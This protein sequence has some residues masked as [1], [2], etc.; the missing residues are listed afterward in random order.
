MNRIYGWIAGRLWRRIFFNHLLIVLVTALILQMIF[1]GFAVSSIRGTS[2]L[3]GDAGWLARSYANSISWIMETGEKQQIHPFLK[4]VRQRSVE[5]PDVEFEVKIKHFYIS[6]PLD[7]I[8]RLIAVR[9]LDLDGTIIAENGIMGTFLSQEIEWDG[10]MDMVLKGEENPYEL[11][12]M[13]HMDGES[14]LLGAA[15]IKQDGGSINGVILVEMHPAIDLGFDTR[16]YVPVFVFVAGFLATSSIGVPA[17]LL[18]MFMAALSGAIVTRSFG[19]RLME[20]GNTAR[21]IS[22]GQLSLRVKDTS[23]DEIGEVGSAFNR[24]ADQLGG[25]LETLDTEKAHVETLLRTRRELVANISHDLRT[26][27][28]T[29]KVHLEDLAKQPERLDE[30]LPILRQETDRLSAMI[31]DL[32]ELARLDSHSLEF[33][34]GVVE[35]DSVIQKVVDNYN[36][37]AWEQHKIILSASLA[38]NLKPIW[39]DVQRVEQILVNLIINGLRFTPQGGLVTVEAHLQI[40]EIIICVSDTGIGISPEHLPYIFER[41]YKGDQAR[42]SDYRHGIP[43]SGSGLG[44]AI[45]KSLVEAMNGSVQA[46]STQGEGTTICLRLPLA[47]AV[48]GEGNPVKT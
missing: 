43:G 10:L 11:S 44:L 23:S 5:L 1:I 33:D 47:E 42:S 17:L 18:A 35:V 26:P 34:M 28:A 38:D 45:V 2:L 48:T 13:I 24:M 30:Y 41:S 36:S 46:S 15:P 40:S 6:V 21:S 7:S 20:L 29:I 8:D 14:L 39:G 37:I 4:M 16:R 27:I 31:K 22:E 32:F 9:V 3:E 12:R 19:R 25:L